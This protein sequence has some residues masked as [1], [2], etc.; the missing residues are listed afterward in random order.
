MF[1]FT[2]GV[3][4]DGVLVTVVGAVPMQ[5]CN[6]KAYLNHIK[7]NRNQ[8]IIPFACVVSVGCV[9]ISGASP[10]VGG[11]PVPGGAVLS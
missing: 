10:S 7:S 3:F 6:V 9:F 5:E 2:A 8:H 4:I 11:G 1:V